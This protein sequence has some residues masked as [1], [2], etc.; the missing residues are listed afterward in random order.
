MEILPGV[1]R[2]IVAAVIGIDPARYGRVAVFYRDV[3]GGD[4]L[5]V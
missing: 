1:G 2:M 5:G 3:Q 4:L